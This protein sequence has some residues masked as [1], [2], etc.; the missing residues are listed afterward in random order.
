MSETSNILDE[1]KADLDRAARETQ[2]AAEIVRALDATEIPDQEES[3]SGKRRIVSL[4]KT[5]TQPEKIAL[6]DDYAA[7]K[8]AATR[9]AMLA[10]VFEFGCIQK[11]SAAIY[12]QLTRYLFRSAEDIERSPGAQE[13]LSSLAEALYQD[14]HICHQLGE[15]PEIATA[16]RELEGIIRALGRDI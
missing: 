8:R 15:S 16:W 13:A 1:V 11:S 6:R 5:E 14:F 4:D 3:D 9:L 12:F 2:E 7:Q 10:Q